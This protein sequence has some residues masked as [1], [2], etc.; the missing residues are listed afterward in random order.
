LRCIIDTISMKN[1]IPNGSRYFERILKFGSDRKTLGKNRTDFYV[2]SVASCSDELLQKYYDH[3]MNFKYL[4]NA[5][6][7]EKLSIRL[8]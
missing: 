1:D 3:L 6:E 7:I 2:N 5:K 8:K 4:D